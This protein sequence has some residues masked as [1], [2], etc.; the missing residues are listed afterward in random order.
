MLDANSFIKIV[1][2][3][4]VVHFEEIPSHEYGEPSNQSEQRFVACQ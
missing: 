3:F 2:S 4:S 1:F